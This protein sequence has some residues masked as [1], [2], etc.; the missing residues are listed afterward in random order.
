MT[1]IRNGAQAYE[2]LRTDVEAMVRYFQRIHEESTSPRLVDQSATYGK[3]RGEDLIK[4]LEKTL[5]P[6]LERIDDRQ[7]GEALKRIALL[8]AEIEAIKARLHTLDEA[9]MM[10]DLTRDKAER[11]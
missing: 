3:Q 1:K 7:Q 11:R 4:Y 9:R 5:E 6:M 8:E 10:P 2:R